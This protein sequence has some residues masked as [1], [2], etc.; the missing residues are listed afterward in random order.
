MRGYGTKIEA[1]RKAKGI[2]QEDL[3]DALGW[4][5]KGHPRISRLE[6]ESPKAPR[7][8]PE[9]FEKLVSKLGLDRVELVEAMG[10]NLDLLPVRANLL[11]DLGRYLAA[12]PKDGQ[13]KLLDFLLLTSRDGGAP[14]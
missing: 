11:G 5:R 7:V 3:A 2:S 1:A 9:V 10:F 13:R 12:I 4:G 6:N 14:Q 8:T